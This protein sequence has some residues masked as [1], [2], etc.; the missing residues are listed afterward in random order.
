MI[1]ENW[2]CEGHEFFLPY[3]EDWKNCGNKL[4]LP[5]EKNNNFRTWT[6]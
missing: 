1:K 6:L 2:I 5:K 3:H 4:K